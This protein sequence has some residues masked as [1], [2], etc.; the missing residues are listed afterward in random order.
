MNGAEND[1]LGAVARPF[2]APIV[3][4]L[5][6]PSAFAAERKGDSTADLGHPRVAQVGQAAPDAVLSNRDKIVK[7]KTA[8]G[9]FIPSSTPR[10]TSDGT[11]RMV[12][13]IGATVTRDK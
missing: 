13:V 5:G 7:I 3:I 2:S 9:F 8:H 6:A 10:T 1:S 12:E 4:P 11:P